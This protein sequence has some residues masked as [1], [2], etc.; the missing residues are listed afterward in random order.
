MIVQL[1][2]VP[3]FT[4]ADGADYTA[5][6]SLTDTAGNSGSSNTDTFSADNTD[7]SAAITSDVVWDNDG[8]V[9]VTYTASDATSGINTCTLTVAGQTHDCAGG[10]GSADF[11]VADG[12]DYTANIAI[13]DVAGNTGSSNTDTFSMDNTDP[14]AAITSDV[15]WENDG[16]VTV[17]YTAS[18]GGSGIAS[19]TLSISDGQTHDCSAGDGS[20]LHNG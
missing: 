4:M 16:V 10:D 15:V 18:D 1:A 14:V 3:D 11:T 8:V 20:R 2:T 7:P 19:C 13:A 9:T 6:I 17:T 5:S 12:A